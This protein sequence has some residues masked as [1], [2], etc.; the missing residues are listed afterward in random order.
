MQRP[1]S[2]R[3]GPRPPDPVWKGLHLATQAGIKTGGRTFQSINNSEPIP[4]FSI[5]SQQESMAVM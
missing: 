2:L 3:S 4:Q 1:P 5:L